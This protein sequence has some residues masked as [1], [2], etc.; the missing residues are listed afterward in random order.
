MEGHVGGGGGGVGGG[1]GTLRATSAATALL[2]HTS[3][4][5]GD[6]HRGDDPFELP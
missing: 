5:R 4:D 1:G 3:T 2:C 6:S